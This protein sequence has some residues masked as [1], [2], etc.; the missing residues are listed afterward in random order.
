MNF[1]EARGFS[2]DW[3]DLRLTDDD[4]FAAQVA[5][6]AN[7]TGPPVVKGTGG[8]RKMRFSVPKKGGK[9]KWIRICY[10]YFPSACVVF[11][12]IAYAKN[13]RDDLTQADKK[14]IKAFIKRERAILS[15]HAIK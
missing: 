14:A 7:P 2:D 4:L 1:V 10:V 11:L 3:D 13:E 9:Q 8:L 5:I 15:K 12:V 6:Q